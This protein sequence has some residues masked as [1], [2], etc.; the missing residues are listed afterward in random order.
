[1]YRLIN[2]VF[3]CVKECNKAQFRRHGAFMVTTSEV[4][5]QLT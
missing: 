3:I 4:F 2:I 1:M 5:T